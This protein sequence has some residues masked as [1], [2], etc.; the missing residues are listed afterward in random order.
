MSLQQGPT[1]SKLLTVKLCLKI[2]SN[3]QLECKQQADYHAQVIHTFLKQHTII[4]TSSNRKIKLTNIRDILHRY[5]NNPTVEALAKKAHF[6]TLTVNGNLTV[7]NAGCT[8]LKNVL[9]QE[10]TT[11][12]QGFIQLELLPL[13][14]LAESKFRLEKALEDF[15]KRHPAIEKNSAAEELKNALKLPFELLQ[16][17]IAHLTRF[18]RFAIEYYEIILNAKESFKSLAEYELSLS[19]LAKEL[20]PLTPI[21]SVSP[22]HE[23]WDE[24]DSVDLAEKLKTRLSITS[25]DDDDMRWAELDAENTSNPFSAPPLFSSTSLS[26]DVPILT[27]FQAVQS[28]ISLKQQIPATQTHHVVTEK[29]KTG[30]EFYTGYK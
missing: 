3:L 17:K 21:E 5:P 2:L 29:L 26:V 23:N 28:S 13:K 1:K 15:V 27:Q 9:A 4:E 19:H 12:N 10:T 14:A 22:V 18:E 8:A 25:N 20:M 7:L 11:F 6:Y 30:T 24:F 16:S